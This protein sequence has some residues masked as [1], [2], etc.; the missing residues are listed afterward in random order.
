G[1]THYYWRMPDFELTNSRG[2]LPLGLDV[3]ANG[4]Q[5]VAP[6]SRTLRGA[7]SVALDIDVADAPGWLLGMVKP[8]PIAAS[9]A[10]DLRTPAGSTG[11]QLSRSSQP[12]TT[13]ATGV[14]FDRGAAYARSAVTELLGQMAAASPGERNTTATRVSLR[15]AELVNADW[16]RLDAD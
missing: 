3:R 8:E 11:D 10:V 12:H 7:Y 14:G 2:R 9:V 5:V 6:P 15:L 1:G 4:G 16:A 13:E